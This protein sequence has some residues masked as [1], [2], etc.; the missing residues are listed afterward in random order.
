MR[1]EVNGKIY[2]IEYNFNTVADTDLLENVGRIQELLIAKQTN[3]Y[4]LIKDMLSVVR[5]M[6][7]AGLEESNPIPD[8][9]EVGRLIEAYLKEGTEEEPRTI[10]SLF[11]LLCEELNNLGFL[12]LTEVTAKKS[13]KVPQDHKK[14]LK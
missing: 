10:L 13:L 11:N 4:T 5:D 7:Q 8:K 9:K 2:K 3:S 14:P 12:Q 6:V 1:L